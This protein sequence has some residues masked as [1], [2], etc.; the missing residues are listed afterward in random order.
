[1]HEPQAARERRLGALARVPP[2]PILMHRG[3]PLLTNVSERARLIIF[4][5]SMKRAPEMIGA[6]H[7]RGHLADMDRTG[8][9]AALILPTLA[10]YLACREDIEPPVVNA[11][12]D[13]YNRWLADFCAV[14]PE[15]LLGAGLI[16]RSDP[17]EMC[18][19]LEWT[20]KQGFRAVMVRPNM[21]RGRRLS[22]P[23]HERFWAMCEDASLAVVIHEGTHTGLQT[24]GT[25]RFSSRFALHACS[26]PMEQMMAL[27]DLIEGG[28]L[29]RYPRLRVG[30]F[31]AGCS[32]LPYW[33]WRLDAVEYRFLK[34]EVAENVRMLPS[35]YFRRQ[36]WVVGEPEEPLFAEVVEALGADRLLYG[37]D[38]PH[39]D[40]DGE[41]APSLARLQAEG[42]A[43]PLLCDNPQRFLG[44]NKSRNT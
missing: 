24:A 35:E 18:R 10:V 16:T 12:A 32:W 17:A 1:M 21:V 6:A 36:C 34:E 42:L 38:F 37:S 19:V 8:I 44:F 25:E 33:L 40:H 9:G 7:P 20:A 27:L 41:Q 22:H 2:S 30:F 29:E 5:Q 3:R 4:E 28:V 31:E 15:R 26:H 14:S 13:A 39:L 23:D 43:K 11:F